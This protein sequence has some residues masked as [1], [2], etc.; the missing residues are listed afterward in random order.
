M[1]KI[2]ARSSIL[3]KAQVQ[4][5]KTLLNEKLKLDSIFIPIKSLGDIDLSSPIK[6]IAKDF[7]GCTSGAKRMEKRCAECPE[8]RL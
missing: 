2:G 7:Q 6:K 3:S 5:V 1:I 4:I 8:N